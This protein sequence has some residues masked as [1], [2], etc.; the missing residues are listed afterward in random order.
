MSGYATRTTV[1]PSRTRAEIEHELEKRGASAFGYN[2]DGQRNVIAFTLK[3]LQ[4]RMD[5]PMPDPG[6]FP[7]YRARNGVKV[8]GQARYDEE[9]KRRWRALLLVVKAKLVAVDE[10]ITSL[11]REFLADVV[12]PDGATVLEKV[13]P[14]IEQSRQAITNVRELREIEG[15]R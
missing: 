10:G 12:L 5:L 7:D 13:S 4:V 11:E 2:R 9:V 3:G 8:S 1:A 6:D 15:S 14:A